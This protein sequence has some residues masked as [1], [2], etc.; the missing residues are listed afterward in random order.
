MALFI[1]CAAFAVEVKNSF[2]DR[3][4]PYTP[5]F[6]GLESRHFNK[7]DN[8]WN[9][10]VNNTRAVSLRSVYVYYSSTQ[11]QEQPYNFRAEN[12]YNPDIQNIKIQIDGADFITIRPRLENQSI[13]MT[14]RIPFFRDQARQI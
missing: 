13:Y 14:M 5:V 9:V 6:I 2:S 7:K 11:K 3:I 12:F 10:N 4:Y 8:W 1:E